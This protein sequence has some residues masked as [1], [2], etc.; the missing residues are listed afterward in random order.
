M[1]KQTGGTA[2]LLNDPQ[3]ASLLWK[4][5]PASMAVRLTRGEFKTW[6]YVQLVSRK[7]VDVILGRTKRLIVT[8]P[9]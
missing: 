8:E 2:S 7:L 9:P 1:V 4:M 5:S 6:P 3:M